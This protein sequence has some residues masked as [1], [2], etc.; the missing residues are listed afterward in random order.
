MESMN[1]E[2]QEEQ[3]RDAMRA[4]LAE[5]APLVMDQSQRTA[6]EIRQELNLIERLQERTDQLDQ[7]KGLLTRMEDGELIRT[8]NQAREQIRT[9][10]RDLRRRL[11]TLA[12]GDPNSEPDYSALQERLAE[13]AAQIEVGVPTISANPDRLELVS[14]PA[15]VAAGIGMGI[16]G[17]GWTAFTTLHAFFMIGGMLKAMG[18]VAF[19]ML[20]FYAIF[21]AVGVGM[22]MSAFNLAAQETIALEGDTLTITKTLGPIRRAKQ[23]RI[24]PK[25]QVRI[26]TTEKQVS[27]GRGRSV[28]VK[29]AAIIFT[30]EDGRPIAVATGTTDANREVMLR[31]I[32]AHLG[33]E[34]TSPVPPPVQA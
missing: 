32:Q 28:P 7:G 23:H 17:L 5:F 8:Y 11:A 15:Q 34:D 30:G 25:L 10:E 2:V 12:P 29:V 1:H 18:P 20:G 6:T 31:Q 22:F 27:H 26:G 21:W 33:Q 13:T 19:A 14:S 16:F 4:W 9:I 3:A 24:N